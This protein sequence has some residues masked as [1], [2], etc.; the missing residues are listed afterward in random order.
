MHI[1]RVTLLGK[2]IFIRCIFIAAF[3]SGVLIQLYMLNKVSKGKNEEQPTNTNE[4]KLTF[5]TS[6][7]VSKS[8]CSEGDDHEVDGLQRAPALNVLEDDDW[9][10]HKDEAPKEDEEY[11][12]DDAY[13]CLADF[14]FLQ[15]EKSYSQKEQM[16]WHSQDL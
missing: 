9:K 11:R 4:N 3:G 7:K 1:S 10:G 6:Y 5:F 15:G 14:P 8:N 16:Q 2:K 12:R 13:L